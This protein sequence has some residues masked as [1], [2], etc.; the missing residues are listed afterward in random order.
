MFSWH[1]EKCG[2][3]NSVDDNFCSKC[4][5]QRRN[6]SQQMMM[7]QVININQGVINNFMCVTP[8][9][10]SDKEYDPVQIIDVSENE[11]KQLPAHNPE[12]VNDEPNN[13]WMTS[14]KVIN[15]LSFAG[16]T[17]FITAFIAVTVY[18]MLM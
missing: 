11:V 15:F 7:A 14:V 4:S 1:C 6:L 5:A 3:Q 17:V 2:S 8:I 16:L 10:Y 18:V 13:F 12:I 9:P